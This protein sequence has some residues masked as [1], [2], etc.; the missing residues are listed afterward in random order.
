MATVIVI[1]LIKVA[2]VNVGACIEAW[3]WHFLWAFTLSDSGC[4]ERGAYLDQA[5]SP[6]SGGTS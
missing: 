4:E 3:C 1:G 2:D 6:G 5:A